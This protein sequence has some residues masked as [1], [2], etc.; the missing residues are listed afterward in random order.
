MKTET[1]HWV[2]AAA[3]AGAVAGIVYGPLEAG[4]VALAAQ[5]SYWTLP[6]RIAGMV[7]GPGIL[8]LPVSPATVLTGSAVHMALALLFGVAIVA[9]ARRAGAKLGVPL[10]AAVGVAIY[11]VSYHLIAPVFFPWMLVAQG[12]HTLVMHIVFGVVTVLVYFG[13]RRRRTRAGAR[14]R[15]QA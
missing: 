12:P 11:L 2:A 8:A 5:T 7:L 3:L 1:L 15:T 6:H 10:A 13:W 4:L 9:P 14:P